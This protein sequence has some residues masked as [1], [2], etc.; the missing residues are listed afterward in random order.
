MNRCIKLSDLRHIPS[1][2]RH[3]LPS[4]LWA[5]ARSA[6]GAAGLKFDNSTG[7][8]SDREGELEGYVDQSQFVPLATEE[9]VMIWEFSRHIANAANRLRQ[10]LAAR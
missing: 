1:V 3:D 6:L 7:R 10:G 4:D 5:L 8:I 9:D 2:T